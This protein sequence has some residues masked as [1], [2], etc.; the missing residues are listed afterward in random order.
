MFLGVNCS[1]FAY[2]HP[3]W[4]LCHKIHKKIWCDFDRALSLIC[5]NKMP[6]R[7]NRGFHCRYYCLLSM[8]RATLCPSSGAQ[9]YYTVV[10]A[11]GNLMLWVSSCWSGVEL[12]VMCPVCR[13]LQHSANW[14]HNP[15]L[16]T[17]PTTWK[18][19]HQIITGSNHCIILLS[20]W[21]WAEWCLKHAE[22][23][24]RSAIK[25]SIASSWH[26]ISTQKDV[27]SNC[28]C[29]IS[30]APSNRKCLSVKVMTKYRTIA[31]FIQH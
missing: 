5:G 15:Q 14:T 3:L 27:H 19:R 31:A 13:M 18:P 8:F 20:S 29:F 22:Q 7:G 9:E 12:R 30:S 23:A 4:C 6:T 11:F 17:R 16:H 26:F 25:T 28:C 21:W 10:A 24:I 1:I 2:D